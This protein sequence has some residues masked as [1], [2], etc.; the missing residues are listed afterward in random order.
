M[1]DCWLG[2]TPPVLGSFDVDIIGTADSLAGDTDML[3]SMLAI[4]VVVI[5]VLFIVLFVLLSSTWWI[6]GGGDWGIR[7]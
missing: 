1:G 5:V 4:V 6:G 7:H 3:V 2:A